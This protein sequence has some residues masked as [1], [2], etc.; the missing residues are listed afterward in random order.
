M[1]TKLLEQDGRNEVAGA[2]EVLGLL[3][4]EGC[5]VTAIRTAL[6]SRLCHHGARPGRGLRAGALTG[7]GI[8][9]LAQRFYRHRKGEC[10]E[11]CED[12]G[13]HWIFEQNSGNRS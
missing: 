12:G 11:K 8:L 7:L 4:L 6:P 2:L 13:E 1:L 3:E 10:T 5:I 9:G